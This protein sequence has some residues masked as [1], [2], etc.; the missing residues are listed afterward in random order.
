MLIGNSDSNIENN[1]S[2][3]KDVNTD[4]FMSDVIEESKT[5]PV[6]VDFW[7]PWCGPCKELGP[8]IEKAVKNASGKVILA[9]VNIDENQ[10]V[11]AQLQIQ[12]IPT[13][14]AFVDGQ[15]VDGFQ[16]AQPESTINA[17]VKKI[18]DLN[19]AGP[20]IEELL[21]NA[22]LQL[23]EK[24]YEAAGEIFETVL[25]IDKKN[26]SGIVGLIKVFLGLK[27]ISVAKTFIEE[28]DNEIKENTSI[29]EVIATV[30]LAE[31]AFNESSKVDELRELIIKEPNNM[32]LKQDLAIS[33]YGAGENESALDCLL[34]SISID[35][36]WNEEAA[37]K[38][39][40]EFFSAI[41]LTDPMVVS[42]R[43]RLSS[44]LFK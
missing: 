43:R 10:A 28:L 26:I 18:A 2:V 13:V 20:N 36:G 41:G 39:L 37:R 42:A 33:L 14:Y 8:H 30:D 31:K 5:T 4:S 21:E 1:S 25:S 40:L 11:A 35:P 34:D 29:K 9:K 12:S 16:G 23:K 27:K 44:L 15:P 19:K 7:A 3:I 6:I 17:F 32:Q 24:N 38:Q 22:D